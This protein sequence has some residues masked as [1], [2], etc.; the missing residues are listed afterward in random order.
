MVRRR[1]SQRRGTALIEIIAA[2]VLLGVALV[3]MLRLAGR[4]AYVQ[5]G[6]EELQIAAGLIDEQLNLVLARGPDNYGPRYSTEGPCDPPFENYR[7]RLEFVAGS[8]GNPYVVTATLSWESPLGP[9]SAS[10]QT[11]VAPRPG[12]NTDADRAPGQMI[13]RNTR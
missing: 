3:A 10:V 5:Q 11:L 2:T 12:E 9:R 6:G 1:T 7:Y 13:E 8:S 4:A